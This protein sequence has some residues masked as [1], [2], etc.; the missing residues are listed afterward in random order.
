MA[1]YAVVLVKYPE[2]EPPDNLW[3]TADCPAMA[4]CVS[5]G[6]T[7]EEALMMIAD[8]MASH[9]EETPDWHGEVF[10]AERTRA[11]K[12]NI[13]AECHEEGGVTELHSVEPRFMTEEEIRNNPRF[14]DLYDPVV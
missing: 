9:L 2:L 10:D 14:A 3:W 6:L 13:I 7:R 12:E 11:E 8:A 5:D 1:K 4:G